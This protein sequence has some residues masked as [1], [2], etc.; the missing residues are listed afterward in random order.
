M[1]AGVA[2]MICDHIS[3]DSIMTIIY[4]LVAGFLGYA[5]KEFALILFKKIK[6]AHLKRIGRVLVFVGVV[7][8]GFSSC[9]PQ[10]RL[11][12][13]IRNHPELKTKETLRIVDTAIFPMI[14]VDSVFS[15]DT[16]VKH[17]TVFITKDG[18]KIRIV[19]RD[20]KIYVNGKCEAD[21]VFIDRRVVVEKILE[22]KESF[23]DFFSKPQFWVCCLCFC[24]AFGFVYKLLR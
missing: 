12:R 18:L 19:Y 14:A 13:L 8:V 21:T 16:L 20:R 11:A 6:F 24:I 7:V 4:P 9:T 23:S 17:D 10:Q 1:L 5:G 22:P 15:I 3:F 2:K